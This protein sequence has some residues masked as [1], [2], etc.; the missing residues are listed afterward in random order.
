MNIF[1]IKWLFIGYLIPKIN[2]NPINIHITYWFNLL[3]T[4]FY[5]ASRN[6]KRKPAQY[7]FYFGRNLVA[8]NFPYN[9]YCLGNKVGL[10]VPISLKNGRIST[11]IPYAKTIMLPFLTKIH[12]SFS[13]QFPTL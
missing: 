11:A 6:K 5:S 10:F 8:V 3:L 7:Y 9:H 2:V 4:T 13:K 1:F 12:L